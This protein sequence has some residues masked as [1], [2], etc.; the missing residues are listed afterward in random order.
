MA[1]AVSI[2]SNALLMLGAQPINDFGDANDRARLASNLW[3]SVR[4]NLLRSHPWNCCIKRV[5]LAPDTAAPP[6]DWAY[7]YTLPGDFMKP[8]AVGEAGAEEAFKVEGRKI[9]C[10]VNPCYLRYVYRNENPASWDSMLVR[11]AELEMASAMAYGITQSASLRDSYR[12]EA[13]LHL[14]RARAVDGQ[15]DT[16]EMLGNERLLTARY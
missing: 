9:L 16:P 3:P 8:L 13:L 5:E 2:C 6:F 1:T 4:D 12:Q 14:K 7:Q 10:D 11:A 15:D